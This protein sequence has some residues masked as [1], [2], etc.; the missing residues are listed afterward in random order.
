M[1][2]RNSVL[3]FH[4]FSRWFLNV[5]VADVEDAWKTY[6]N[7]NRNGSSDAPMS[8]SLYSKMATSADGDP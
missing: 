6:P 1:V 4:W 7:G 2:F 8:V 3:V 5:G